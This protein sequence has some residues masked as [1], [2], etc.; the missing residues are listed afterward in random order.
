MN[1]NSKSK[2]AFHLLQLANKLETSITFDNES[3]GQ[4]WFSLIQLHGGVQACIELLRPRKLYIKELIS[5]ME[6]INSISCSIAEN[7]GE[8][9]LIDKPTNLS[10]TSKN[11]VQSSNI[12]ISLLNNRTEKSQGEV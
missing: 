12:T 5:F 2:D 1:T 8:K 10:C 3:L 7:S 6:T 11:N 9:H 4:K